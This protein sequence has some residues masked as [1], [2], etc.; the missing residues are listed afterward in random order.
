MYYAVESIENLVS[1]GGAPVVSLLGEQTLCIVVRVAED[2]GGL[3]STPP[4][5]RYDHFLTL[6][7][8][9]TI[10]TSGIDDPLEQETID[11]PSAQMTINAIEE[12]IRNASPNLPQDDTHGNKVCNSDDPLG[13]IAR[14]E[15][16]SLIG[17]QRS[18]TL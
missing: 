9:V 15:M 10:A 4:Q 14:P 11:S 3:S 13:I 12:R 5:H 17:Q 8:Q 6:P 2:A 1:S 7:Q 16:Q 18:F